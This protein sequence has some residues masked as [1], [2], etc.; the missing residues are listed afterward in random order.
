[1]LN[2]LRVKDFTLFSEADFQ[3]APGLNVVIGENGTGKSHLLKLAYS[4]TKSLAGSTRKE[5]E[6]RADSPTKTHL[7][8][9][10][11][12]RLRGVFRPDE[13]GRLARRQTGRSRSEVEAGF[14]KAALGT[15]FSFNSSSRSEVTID[16]L[17]TQ[18]IDKE[19]QSV[20]L[21]TRE[22]LT[23]AP[24]FTALFETTTLPFEE[25]WR[26]T[27]TLLEAPLA[28]GP[29]L[30]TITFLLAPLEEE[31][32]GQ[33]VLKPGQG[34][35]LVS[36]DGTLEMYLVAEGMRKLAMLARLVATG[37]LAGGGYLFWDEPE[38]NMNPVALRLLARTI[39]QL[40]N[41]GTQVFVATHSL[42]LMRELDILHREK[43][44]EFAA[45]ETRH[46]GLHRV[47]S[48]IKVMQG[49]S[50]DE[51]GAIAALDADLH[52]SDRYM[53]IEAMM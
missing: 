33:V 7:Q 37:S 13:L 4:V 10:I 32:G 45:V 47:A 8:G 3:F 17:P 40:C 20:F 39:L 14:N 53:A 42:F 6:M 26:D 18:W 15:A 41:A 22:L 5:R 19:Q 38:S 46:I 44:S 35:Y 36:S 51:V 12:D 2:R 23:I 24:G 34:F 27:C 30:K 16:K 11:A 31:L 29:R 28:R 1:M 48:G 21:P 9:V 49:E 52:Q 50:V 25:T 43:G